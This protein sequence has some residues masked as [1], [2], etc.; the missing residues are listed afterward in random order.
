KYV[1]SPSMANNLKDCLKRHEHI[2]KQEKKINISNAMLSRSIREF[3]SRITSKCFGY[4]TVDHYYRDA[5]SYF[6]VT[7]VRVPLL[8]LNAED[9]PIVPAECLPFDETIWCI[10][11]LSEFCIAIFEANDPND[12]SKTILKTSEDTSSSEES[13]VVD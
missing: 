8:C 3:D 1:Y 7:K 10:K 2:M 13:T 11:P 6:Y 12:G 4:E 5:S 9:D